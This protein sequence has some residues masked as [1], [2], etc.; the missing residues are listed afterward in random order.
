MVIQ[1]ADKG[2]CMVTWDRKDYL[3]KAD[4]QLS[5]YKIYRDVNC[6]KKM[7]SLLVDKSN[8]IFPSLS[9][10]KYILEKEVKYF[11]YNNKN[12]TNLGRLYFLLKIYKRLFNV[13][14]I[15]V[16]SNCGTTSY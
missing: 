5:D 7:L 4:R 3:K 11:T 9:R 13:P 12:A 16:I 14:G 8:K 6:T 15:P 1:S 10:K 2:S